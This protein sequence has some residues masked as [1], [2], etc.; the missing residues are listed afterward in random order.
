MDQICEEFVLA[1]GASE[2][3]K[4]L[5]KRRIKIILVSGGVG[6]IGKKVLG[7]LWGFID[8]WFINKF[9]FDDTTG[10]LKKI[11]PTRFDFEGKERAIER[12]CLSWDIDIKHEAAFVGD[13]RNDQLHS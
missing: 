4:E 2:L 3:I 12:M 1:P 10:I 8:R 6:I 11:E 5:K 13:A 7:D 9:Y